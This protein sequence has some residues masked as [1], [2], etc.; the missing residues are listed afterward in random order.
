MMIFF[1]VGIGIM[2]AVGYVYRRRILWWLISSFWYLATLYISYKLDKKRKQLKA[3]QSFKYTGKHEIPIEDTNFFVYEYQKDRIK[4]IVFDCQDKTPMLK[5]VEEKTQQNLIFKHNVL[6]CSINDE[7]H[8]NDDECL[9]DITNRWRE[10]LYH[11]QD[12]AESSKLKYFFTFISSVYGLQNIKDK[13]LVTYHNDDTFSQHK[14][15]ISEIWDT[16]F[17]ELNNIGK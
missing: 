2:S 4:M 11:Y 9:L 17:Y 5:N 13:Y 12:S 8:L 14:Y 7:I 6:N 16:Y 15:K 3:I 10:C 1:Y